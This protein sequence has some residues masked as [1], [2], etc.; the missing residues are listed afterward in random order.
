MFLKDSGKQ[1]RPDGAQP[2]I[3]SALKLGKDLPQRERTA[4]MTI[5]RMLVFDL[6]LYSCVE[7]RGFREPMNHMEKLYKIPSRTTFS[8]TVIPELY[9]DTVTAVKERMHADF[10]EGV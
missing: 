2:L 10:W 6:Q 4:M 1:G 7:N 9:R 8:R 5:A 3:K